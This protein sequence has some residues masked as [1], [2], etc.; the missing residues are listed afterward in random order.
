MASCP[1]SMST[2]LLSCKQ[3]ED[4]LNPTVKVIDEDIKQYW[5]Q[6]GPCF[7]LVFICILSHW[8]LPFGHDH[9]TNSLSSEKSTH[10]ICIFY[11]YHSLQFN[12]YHWGK[13]Q[14]RMWMCL[15]RVTGVFGE[16]QT[17]SWAQKKHFCT[18]NNNEKSLVFSTILMVRNKKKFTY[19]GKS[20]FV[21]LN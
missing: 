8:P 19:C 12:L 21:C 15:V 13:G 6:Y 5:S 10:Q 14:G 3:A 1:S 2:S 9:P 18:N 20:C 17:N 11:L 4:A 7:L 16:K